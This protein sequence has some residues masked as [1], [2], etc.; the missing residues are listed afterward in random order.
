MC[1]F[2]DDALE[3]CIIQLKLVFLEYF[4]KN[5]FLL[6]GINYLETFC[7]KQLL[8]IFTDKTSTKSMV[9]TDE[10]GWILRTYEICYSLCHFSGGFICKSHAENV[11]RI[12]SIF[13]YKIC[14]TADKKFCF[15]GTSSCNY[16]YKS[17]SIFL[18]QAA[19]YHSVL[20]RYP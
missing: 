13:L 4:F 16:A 12:D 15:S 19:V 14:I 1:N 11:C 9:G 2:F 5:R 20:Q 7:K 10:W 3:V 18:R 17:F 6:P 8:R